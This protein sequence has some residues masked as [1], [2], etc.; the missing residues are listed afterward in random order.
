MAADQ[1]YRIGEFILPTPEFTSIE[2]IKEY[3]RLLNQAIAE[4]DNEL[5]N[6][7]NQLHIEYT[8]TA[9]SDAPYE[10]EPVLRIYNNGGTIY[11][12]VYINSAWKSVQ[13]S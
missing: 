12:Y 6:K 2:G 4:R 5:K 8:T 3:L 10:P 11:L 9:P 13:L 1:N 7:L